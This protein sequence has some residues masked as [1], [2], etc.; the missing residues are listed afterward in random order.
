MHRCLQ[1][2]ALH[3][4]LLPKA[5][6]KNLNHSVAYTQQKQDLR[7]DYRGSLV[8]SFLPANL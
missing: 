6:I 2:I 7:H 4:M 3:G 8:S 1:T 5:S